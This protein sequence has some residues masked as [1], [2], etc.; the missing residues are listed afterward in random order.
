[1]Q[2]LFDSPAMAL[3]YAKSRPAV[4]PEVIALV[5]QRLNIQNPIARAL[6]LGC[7][8]GV[9]TAALQ[10]IA[11]KPIGIEP[12]HDMLRFGS[13]IAPG[14]HFACGRAEAMPVL[15]ASME[16]IT[17]AGSLNFADLSFGLPELR[18]VLRPASHL[19][20]YDFSQGSDFTDSDKLTGWHREF[21]T[22]YPSP[23]TRLFDPRELNLG[24]NGLELRHF[25]PF[26]IPLPIEP[27]FYLDYAMTETNVA[28][29]ESRG[30]PRAEIR[31]WCAQSLAGVFDGVTRDVLFK[32]YV[33]YV[34]RL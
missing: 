17:A 14:A 4:H 33:A 2:S 8:A 23:S 5:R 21:K 28:A 20:I 6:D 26:A 16:L 22:R 25:D 3:G 9:S 24:V 27:G 34:R 11:P 31:E 12:F 30:A 32:G 1:M 15:S 29:A 19:V 18:R 10:S 13:A 7:G